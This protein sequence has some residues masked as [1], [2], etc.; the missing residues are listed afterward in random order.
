[1]EDDGAI[2]PG[3]RYAL[4]HGDWQTVLRAYIDGGLSQSIIAARTGVSQSQISRLAAGCSR[5]PGLATIRALCDGLGI[6]RSYAG[7]IDREVDETN[8]RHRYGSE[9]VRQAVRALRAELPA[10]KATAAL[11]ER[12]HA[13]YRGLA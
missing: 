8:R 12:L 5:D 11:D 13:A 9:R 6:R 2:R 4:A 1:M 7:L 10:G 3:M